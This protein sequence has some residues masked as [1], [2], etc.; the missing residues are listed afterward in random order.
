MSKML[1]LNFADF[2]SNKNQKSYFKFDAFDLE[3]KTLYPFFTEQQYCAIPDGA[4]PTK[5]EQRDTFPRIAEVD[6]SFRQ[7]TDKDGVVRYA[8]NINAIVNWK[9]IDLKSFKI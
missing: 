6:Y 2:Q 4:I 9:P 1:I 8:P 7:Y 5:Q 3:Q